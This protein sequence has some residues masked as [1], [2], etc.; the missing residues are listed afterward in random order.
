[1]QF[2][3]LVQFFK[4]SPSLIR[5]AR[6][7]AFWQTKTHGWP[8]ASW[9]I[10]FRAFWKNVP[11]DQTYFISQEL[12]EILGTFSFHCTLGPIARQTYDHNFLDIKVKMQGAYSWSKV[13]G[14]AQKCIHPRNRTLVHN[15]YLLPGWRSKKLPRCNLDQLTSGAWHI[16]I[17]IACLFIS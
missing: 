7:I 4:C 16:W 8:R 15:H 3:S 9:E 12:F 6:F 17:A 5:A 14:L 1:M 10:D 13:S 2:Q 11:H